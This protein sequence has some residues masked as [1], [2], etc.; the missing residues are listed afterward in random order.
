MACPRNT[1]AE[2]I[3]NFLA[4]SP[5]ST[6]LKCQ[7]GRE[8][9]WAVGNASLGSRGDRRAFCMYALAFQP[10]R[11][12]KKYCDIFSDLQKS[13]NSRKTYHIFFI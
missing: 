12:K 3:L 13:E 1:G 11:I 2:F 4:P 8:A 9:S 5:M 6:L 10:S 7:S